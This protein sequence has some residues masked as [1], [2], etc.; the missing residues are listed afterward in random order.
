MR[1]WRAGTDV[2]PSLCRI[3]AKFYR[4]SL[5]PSTGALPHPCW[6]KS[7]L[8]PDCLPEEAT[9]AAVMPLAAADG[10]VLRLQSPNVMLDPAQV[11]VESTF[12]RELLDYVVQDGRRVGAPL[13]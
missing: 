11:Q 3:R 4:I 2:L 13:A 7:A 12:G 6:P 10:D 1:L 8:T 5:P 9:F